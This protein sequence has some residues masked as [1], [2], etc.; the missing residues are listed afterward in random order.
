MEKGLCYANSS[1]FFS[2]EDLDAPVADTH[3]L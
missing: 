3:I 1:P 2:F